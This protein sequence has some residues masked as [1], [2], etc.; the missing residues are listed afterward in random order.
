MAITT[1]DFFDKLLKKSSE[2]GRMRWNAI[3]EE[4]LDIYES[5]F[6]QEKRMLTREEFWK[7]LFE[8]YIQTELKKKEILHISKN[9][10]HKS[11][12]LDIVNI[13]IDDPPEWKERVSS[14]R[15]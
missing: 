2:S 9:N 12:L 5:K 7:I 14:F 6:T 15:Y 13:G 4:I 3:V 1:E 8:P 11:F 10:E